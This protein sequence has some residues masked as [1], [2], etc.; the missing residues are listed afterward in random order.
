[1][2][3]HC[4]TGGWLKGSGTD[5]SQLA[6]LLPAIL[7]GKRFGLVREVRNRKVRINFNCYVC[8]AL[9]VKDVKLMTA[10]LNLYT[11]YKP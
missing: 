3:L 6:L 5:P 8:K 11:R 4:F 2:Q 1:M 9:T 7:G 10:I